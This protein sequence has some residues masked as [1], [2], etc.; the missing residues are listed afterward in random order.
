MSRKKRRKYE[1][2]IFG[3]HRVVFGGAFS[4]SRARLQVI[5]T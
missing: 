1:S 5:R 3:S 4:L 2:F